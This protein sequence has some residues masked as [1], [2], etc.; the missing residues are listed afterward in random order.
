MADALAV[1]LCV[2]GEEVRVRIEALPNYEGLVV[3]HDGT[4]RLTSGFPLVS[5]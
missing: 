1:A 2:G 3:D 4:T 5:G